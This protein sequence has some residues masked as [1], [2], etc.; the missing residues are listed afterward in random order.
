MTPN[1]HTG[2][3]P[4]L[5]SL[6]TSI[7]HDVQDLF[8]QQLDLFKHEVESNLR[9]TREATVSLVV[10]L[11]CLLLGSILLC[12]TI[13]YLLNW[14]LPA[15]HLWVCFLIVTGLVGI[16]GAIL[17]Y[18]ARQEF[19]SVHALPEES[20]EAMKENLEWTTKPR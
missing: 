7:L 6:A 17:A 1:L 16:P 5:A 13:V 11:L 20:A 14:L 9:K 4:G 2:S 19:R 18:T 15:L 12:L 3:D 10:G 8:K